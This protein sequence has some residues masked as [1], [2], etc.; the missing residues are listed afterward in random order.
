MEKIILTDADGVLL[1]GSTHL[2]IWL[3]AKGYT[4]VRDGNKE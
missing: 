4:Q 1:N 2:C 3:E